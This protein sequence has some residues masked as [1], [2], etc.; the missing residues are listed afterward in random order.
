[1]NQF[2]NLGKKNKYAV[3]GGV[4][5]AVIALIAMMM[6]GSKAYATEDYWD[7]VVGDKVVATVNSESSAK[8]VIKG[9]EENFVG[10]NAAVESIKVDPEIK[11]V[12]RHVSVDEAPKTDSVKDAVNTLLTG[13]VEKK[14]Y[15][16]QDGDTIWDIAVDHGYSYD[17]FVNMNKDKNLELI[18]PGDTLNLV[19]VQP[20]VNVEVTQVMETKEVYEAEVQYEETADLYEGEEEV[21]EE[22]EVGEKALKVRLVTVNGNETGKEV[23][24]ETVVKEPKAKIVLKGTKK[25]PTP[26]VSTSR[27]G[28]TRSANYASAASYSGNGASV[29]A[30]ARQFVG[31]PYVYG[32]KSLTNGADC[33][34]FVYSVY[35]NFGVNIGMS[36]TNGVSVPVSQMQPGDVL[37]YGGHYSMYAGGGEEVHALN[38]SM[39]IRVTPLGWS[40]AGPILDVRRFV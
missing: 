26:A 36:A 6:Y 23:L 21:K 13:N 19:A 27:A 4:A 8:K 5:L 37:I 20:Y 12:Q 24:E 38:P 28:V 3:A 33:Y 7:I 1:M 25:K 35:Q 29:A 32:G 18:L 11:T 31:N 10:E 39:G 30:F 9:V 14:E 34:G 40:N 17:E 15:V 22:G 16:V 2:I